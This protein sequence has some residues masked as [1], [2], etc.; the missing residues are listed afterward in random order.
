M[1]CSNKVP[2][3]YT[4]DAKDKVRN[5]NVNANQ[6]LCQPWQLWC[7]AYYNKVPI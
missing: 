3:A 4:V 7:N 6:G 5:K 2:L 1:F